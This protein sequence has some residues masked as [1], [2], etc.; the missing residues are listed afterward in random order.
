MLLDPDEID[1]DEGNREHATRHGVSVGEITQ[2]L[3]NQPTV[4]R[5]RR[6][7]PGDYY[8]FGVTDGGRRVVVV[9]AWDAGRRVVRPIT[10]WEQG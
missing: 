9:V 8:V 6:G 4:R 3:L 2:A 7:R 5:N 1:W 10:A